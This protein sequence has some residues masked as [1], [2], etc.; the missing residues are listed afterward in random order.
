M[1]IA[2]MTRTVRWLV[3]AVIAAALLCETGWAATY[4]A[5]TCSRAD[6]G[7][8]FAAEIASAADGDIITIPAGTCTW[9]TQ[10]SATFTKSVTIQGAGAI[11]ATSGGS[12]T[13]GTDQTV[14]LDH[15]SSN[16]DSIMRL[17]TTTRKSLRV[18]G[19]AL[20]QDSS[21]VTASNGMLAIFGTSHSVRVD[22]CHI[23]SYISGN[24]GLVVWDNVLG[25]ADHDLFDKNNSGDIILNSAAFYNGNI[26]NGS[27]ADGGQTSWADTD[28]WGTDQ[29]FYVEDS[30]FNGGD[31]TSD[32]QIGGRWIMRYSTGLNVLVAN[33]GT[34]VGANRSCRAFEFYNN[35]FTSS[36]I[37]GGETAGSLGGPAL[38][39]G[40]N[41]VNNRYIFGMADVRLSNAT[42]VEDPSPT[43]WGYC[44]GAP[45]TTGTASI[46]GGTTALT[47]TGFNTGWPSGSMIIIAGASCTVNGRT[48][49]TCQISTVNSSTSITLSSPSRTTVI[50]GA[51]TVGSPWDGNSVASGYP[52]LDSPARGAGDLLAWTGGGF[53]VVNTTSGTAAWPHQ[54]LDPIYVWGNAY[55]GPG[56]DPQGIV[57]DHTGILQ[58]NVDYYQQ[59]GPGSYGEQGSFDGT[60]GV[61]QGLLSARTSTCTAGP[62]GNTPGVGYWAT[63]TNTL[64]VCNPTNTWTAYYTPYTYPHPLTQTAPASP[65]NLV[66][67]PK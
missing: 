35:N 36:S 50:G 18:T 54:V 29:F 42:Y 13:T 14:I 57:V 19:I 66:A 61:G 22:S 17:T 43:G 4:P 21:S 27:S 33:H 56:Y 15:L 32:C 34:N 45:Y 41:S 20:T 62:G 26:W 46:T 28:H 49:V 47:G 60:K 2:S 9:T 53:P 67:T 3:F 48:G 64:Y 12:S 10:L 39:W 31:Y 65:T 37:N 30:Q 63:D 24:K 25:V 1:K 16:S 11:S 52:C 38:A 8:A 55:T 59:F 5:T 51:Y 40:N 23:T 44:G 6:V 58:D 7:N